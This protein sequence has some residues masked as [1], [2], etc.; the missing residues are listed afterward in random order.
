MV[1]L[2]DGEERRRSRVITR[3]KKATGRT[4]GLFFN[5]I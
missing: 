4:L 5:K 2:E 3:R 1:R